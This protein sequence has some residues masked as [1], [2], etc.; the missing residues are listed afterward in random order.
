[1]NWGLP[2]VV[3][4][5]RDDT[6]TPVHRGVRGRSEAVLERVTR[7]LFDLAITVWVVM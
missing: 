2:V 5:V 4:V 1:M 3:G 6:D 7:P